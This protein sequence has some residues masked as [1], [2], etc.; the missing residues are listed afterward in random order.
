MTLTREMTGRA[1]C[2]GGGRHFV[3]GAV[4]AVADF[5]FVL[6]RLEMDVAGPVL[7]RLGRGRG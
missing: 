2:L 3:E 4:H 7:R 1:R 6:K 5:E